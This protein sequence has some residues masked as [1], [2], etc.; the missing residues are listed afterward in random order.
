MASCNLSSFSIDKQAILLGLIK[1]ERLDIACI[2]ESHWK[3]DEIKD[4]ITKC[5]K[6]FSPCKVYASHADPKDKSAGII[7]IVKGTL[8]RK[9]ISF[10]EIIQ[11]RLSV[12]KLECDHGLVNVINWYGYHK[13]GGPFNKLLNRLSELI[14]ECMFHNEHIVI[15]GDLNINTLYGKIKKKAKILKDWLE[16]YNLSDL[17]PTP[18][19]PSFKLSRGSDRPYLTRPDHIISSFHAPSRLWDVE[20]FLQH[21]MLCVELPLFNC[22]PLPCFQSKFDNVKFNLKG[23]NDA[24]DSIN[25]K[26]SNFELGSF[27]D[28][29]TDL[30]QQFSRPAKASPLITDNSEYRELER[31]RKALQKSKWGKNSSRTKEFMTENNLTDVKLAYKLVVEKQRCNILQALKQRKDVFKKAVNNLRTKK[32][33]SYA[34]QNEK[35]LSSIFSASNVSPDQVLSHF[36]KMFN[37]SLGSSQLND[38]LIQNHSALASFHFAAAS[39]NS[40]GNTIRKMKNSMY[41]ID[42]I[43]MEVFKAMNEAALAKLSDV[44]NE[45]IVNGKPIPDSWKSG[46][47]LPIPKCNNPHSLNDFRPIV[48][49]P[50]IYRIF[51]SFINSQLMHIVE[52]HQLIHSSQRGFRPN[53]STTDQLVVVKSIAA[54]YRQQKKPFFFCTLDIKNAYGSV[55]HSK[56][57]QILSLTGFNNS[58]RQTV[59]NMI[60][61]HRIKVFANGSTSPAFEAK[62]GVPQGDPISPLVFNLYFNAVTHVVD[63]FKGVTIEGEKVV[64]L[65]YADDI[66]VMSE[67]A[68]ELTQILS[69]LNSIALQL[70]LH[71]ATHKCKVFGV[72]KSGIKSRAK[73]YLN[74]SNINSPKDP[75]DYL[76]ARLANNLNWLPQKNKLIEKVQ[77]RLSLFKP[78]HLRLETVSTVLMSKV[79]SIPR[80]L[81]SVDAVPLSTLT[82][83]ES[84]ISGSI[85]KKLGCNFK[86]SK[87][88][89]YG[90]KR[91]GGLGLTSPVDVL[92]IECTASV[93]RFVNSSSTITRNIARASIQKALRGKSTDS[94]WTNAALNI[95]KL[96]AYF[97]PTESGWVLCDRSSHKPITNLRND[98]LELK[99]SKKTISELGQLDANLNWHLST[100]SFWRNF[101]L[102]YYQQRLLFLNLLL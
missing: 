19:R 72:T 22:A 6:F 33:F 46:L 76:G 60:V 101:H 31:V 25:A 61:G 55:V 87:A 38:N 23:Y 15:L 34:F 86:L 14:D 74:G 20:M 89:I 85:K 17:T 63:S 81:S 70:G 79:L 9:I 52:N 93:C 44:F 26:I 82:K 28:S 18:T 36:D 62:F 75:M 64:I 41:G 27:Q 90:D 97:N 65:L 39:P 43:P 50:L 21:K 102:S 40:I 29:L 54:K 59:M 95:N 84:N 53:A 77:T 80:Y 12:L 71:F 100:V 13:T 5:A 1:Q 69:R 73:I 42:R 16:L 24:L 49:L 2:Q 83:L 67:T 48:V 11:G 58:V 8:Q 68:Q 94:L 91:H 51:S 3:P 98:I 10:E 30:C 47:L 45:I 66:I 56:L 7:T 88:V 99:R 92:D 78:R 4:N 37:D 35:R 57:N 96:N 32:P